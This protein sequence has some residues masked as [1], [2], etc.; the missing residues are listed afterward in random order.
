VVP[1]KGV[2]PVDSLMLSLRYGFVE[3]PDPEW[4]AVYEVRL[5][6]DQFTVR[7]REGRLEQVVRGQPGVSPDAVIDTDPATFGAVMTAEQTPQEAVASKALTVAG[8]D[9][10]SGM[11]LLA[12]ARM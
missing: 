8:R 7:V 2:I 12:A 3:D 6:R 1:L 4:N 5:G 10:A 9:T 11:R